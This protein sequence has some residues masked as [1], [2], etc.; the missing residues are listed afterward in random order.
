MISWAVVENYMTEKYLQR[1]K[2]LKNGNRIIYNNQLSCLQIQFVW[3][4]FHIL[5]PYTCSILY[6]DIL[7]DTIKTIS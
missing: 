6:P 5:V 1:E 2:Q 7:A 3:S 4:L